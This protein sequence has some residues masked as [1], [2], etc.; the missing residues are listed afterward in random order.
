MNIVHSD[1]RIGLLLPLTSMETAREKYQYNINFGKEVKKETPVTNGIITQKV[2]QNY[3]YMCDRVTVN[4]KKC[5]C[6]ILLKYSLEVL[7]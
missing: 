4:I 2:S 7:C 5:H 1:V 6:T 3:Q